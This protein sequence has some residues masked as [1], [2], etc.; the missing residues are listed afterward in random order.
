MDGR[1]T[2]VSTID[3]LEWVLLTLRREWRQYEGASRPLTWRRIEKNLSPTIRRPVFVIGAP[4]SGTSFL[5]RC[6]GRLPEVSYHFEPAATQRAAQHVYFDRWSF[7]RAAQFYRTV[8]RWLLRIHFDGDLRYA[9]KSPRNCFLVPFLHRVFPEAH[10]VHIIRD[11]RDAALSHSKKPWLQ[12]A[13]EGSGEQGVGGHQFGPYARFWVEE[14]RV[15]EFETTSD[16]HRCVWAW[17]RHVERALWA[18]E[19]L[20]PQKYHEVRYEQLVRTPVDAGTRLLDALGIHRKASRT[21]FLD[22][23][24]TAHDESV[25]KWK[26]E[27][28]AEQRRSVREEAGAVL[29][30]LG[31]IGGVEARDERAS[32]SDHRPSE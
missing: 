31:Y 3:L 4:R 25:G 17:R 2:P 26:Q 30:R 19:E 7:E 32:G 14:D 22:Q 29:E 16:Y 21:R 11:G 1:P 10:F 27:L 20:H 6:I 9:D 12:A 28:S 8:Y 24:R 23:A 13:A 18:R 5:G 15:E